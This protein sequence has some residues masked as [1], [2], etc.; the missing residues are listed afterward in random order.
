MPNKSQIFST[1]HRRYVVTHPTKPSVI[2]GLLAFE[3]FKKSPKIDQSSQMVGEYQQQTRGA[4]PATGV[5]DKV[6]LR[7]PPH[8]SHVRVALSPKT[9]GFG[10]LRNLALFQQ[11]L[12]SPWHMAQGD[13]T[14]M[15]FWEAQNHVFSPQEIQRKHEFHLASRDPNPRAATVSVLSQL[16]IH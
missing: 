15:K 9:H 14:T 1:I 12:T 16:D 2:V 4:S 8:N 3:T 6:P 11:Q 7:K 5:V 13:H 10:V